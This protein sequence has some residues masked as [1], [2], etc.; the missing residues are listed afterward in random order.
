MNDWML[1][2]DL[3]EYVQKALKD[4]IVIIDRLQIISLLLTKLV[5]H[6]IQY[7]SFAGYLLDIEVLTVWEILWF[8]IP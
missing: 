3:L 2:Y 5:L 1:C 8:S 7:Y 4:F 6:S